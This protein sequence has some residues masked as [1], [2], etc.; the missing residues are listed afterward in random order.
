MMSRT[1]S[2]ENENFK[3]CGE[4]GHQFQ[5]IDEAHDFENFEAT[6][7]CVVCGAHVEVTGDI[8]TDDGRH[9]GWVKSR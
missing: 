5:T 1:T 3:K 9:I 8:R 4:Q 6:L 7:E 2:Y